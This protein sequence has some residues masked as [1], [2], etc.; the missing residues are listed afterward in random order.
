MSDGVFDSWPC[1]LQLSPSDDMPVV[2]EYKRINGG[3][4]SFKF[5]AQLSRSS[6]K[7]CKGGMVC[8]AYVAPKTHMHHIAFTGARLWVV[9][10]ASGF[11]R[12]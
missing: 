12:V 2:L 1:S 3:S 10:F 4:A 5:G 7:K 11:P 9:V 6:P 8:V